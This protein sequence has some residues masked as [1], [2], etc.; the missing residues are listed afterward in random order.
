MIHTFLFL[1]TFILVLFNPTNL[2]AN[3]FLLL[4][5]LENVL[6]VLLLWDWRCAMKKIENIFTKFI[7]KCAQGFFRNNK[8]VVL[9]NPLCLV[10][11]LNIYNCICMRVFLQILTTI[12]IK[13]FGFL[14]NFFILHTCIYIFWKNVYKFSMTTFINY[15]P[16]DWTC[17]WYS[18]DWCGV[19][20]KALSCVLGVIWGHRF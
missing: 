11:K 5:I 16:S 19:S 1:K 20:I 18:M 17:V 3:Y 12:L 10:F 9:G 14:K 2:F 13:V 7:S 15:F 6:S 8:F 4:L